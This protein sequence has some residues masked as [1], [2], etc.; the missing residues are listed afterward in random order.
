MAIILSIETSTSVCAAA[1]HESGNLIASQELHTPRSAASQLAVMVERLFSEAKISMKRL[2]AVAVSAGPGSYTGLRIGVATPADIREVWFKDI[3]WL[4]VPQARKIVRARQAL[5][6]RGKITMPLTKQ[7]F[8]VHVR[9]GSRIDGK[10]F[11]FR[12]DCHGLCLFPA[13]DASHFS[14]LWAF[15]E[16]IEKHRIGPLLG[17]ALISDKVATAA[18]IDAGLAEQKRKRE[19]PLGEYLQAALV[20]SAEQLIQALKRQKSMP[21]VRLGEVLVQENMVTEHELRDALRAQENDRKAP[22]GEFL[23]S[24]GLVSE[25]ALGA[26][27]AKKLGV[28]FVDLRNFTVDPKVLRL[29]PEDIARIH[30]VLP[31]YL[32]EGRLLVFSVKDPA[33]WEPT[34]AI[35]FCCGL[36]VEPVMATKSDLAWAID[37]YYTEQRND[38][39]S[40]ASVLDALFG[41]QEKNS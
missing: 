22:I 24:M 12:M 5:E 2:N 30:Q 41:N 27:L 18:V 11:S 9:G 16:A 8:E 34:Q 20:V 40:T 25:E 31:L 39:V 35:Q 1:L 4:S 13:T 14:F 7:E 10:T 28:P 19:Q 33:Q 6:N 3:A 36:L 38:T 15:N 29:V 32:D 21:G 37:K 17:K 26:T 23:V